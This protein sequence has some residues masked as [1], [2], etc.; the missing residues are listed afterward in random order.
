[1]S[2]VRPNR[3]TFLQVTAGAGLAA[4]AAS[5]VSARTIGANDKIGIGFI[6]VGGRGMGHVNTCKALADEGEKIALVAVCDAY[7]PR[8]EDVAKKFNMK[9]YKRHQDL[10]ADKDVDVSS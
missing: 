2:N 5:R 7:G 3:R 1:M 6:G 9:P 8:R 10:L 4:V